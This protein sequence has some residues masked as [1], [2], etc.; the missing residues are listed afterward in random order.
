MNL[1]PGLRRFGAATSSFEELQPIQPTSRTAHPSSPQVFAERL[2]NC[3]KYAKS[4]F[5]LRPYDAAA[6][7]TA[8][9]RIAGHAEIL[10]EF[11]SGT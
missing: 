9:A 7:Y 1:L 5:C 11:V 8:P 6:L 4:Q 3:K 2:E 10:S